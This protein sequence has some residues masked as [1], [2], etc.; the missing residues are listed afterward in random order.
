MNTQ[1][2]IARDCGPSEN[3]IRSHAGERA[4]DI[5]REDCVRALKD[6]RAGTN[7]QSAWSAGRR[8]ATVRFGREA[9]RAAWPVT[10]WIYLR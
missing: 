5:R 10:S 4:V 1:S 6:A 7:R 9:R 3:T 2:S 8:G